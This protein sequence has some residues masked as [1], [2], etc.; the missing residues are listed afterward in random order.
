M[1]FSVIFRF[2]VDVSRNLILVEFGEILVLV[3]FGRILR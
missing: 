1:W 3:E 2:L